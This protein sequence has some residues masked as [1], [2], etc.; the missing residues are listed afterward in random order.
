MKVTINKGA[1]VA[2]DKIHVRG[3]LFW[4]QCSPPHHEYFHD[5]YKRLTKSPEATFSAEWKG[6]YGECRR[7][8]Y[9]EGDLS[10]D[11]EGYG[12]I[13]VWDKEGVTEIV[14]EI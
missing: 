2:Q 10:D 5:E 13:L 9:G 14:N 12:A 3:L 4:P 7:F 1:M 8:G 11:A 6:K